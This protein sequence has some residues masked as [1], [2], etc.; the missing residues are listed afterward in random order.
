M[1]SPGEQ[2]HAP[3]TDRPLTYSNPAELRSDRVLGLRQVSPADNGSGKTTVEYVCLPSSIHSSDP[4]SI[5]AIH[6]LDTESPHTWEF[7]K[8]DGSTVINWLADGDMLPAAVPEARIF[9]Y[10]WDAGCFQDAPVETL[11]GHATTLL[12]ALVAEYGGAKM[13]PILFVASC[14]GGLVV[15]EVC[16]PHGK[17]RMATDI[18]RPSIVPRSSTATETFCV[19][20]LA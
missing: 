1:V 17:L 2:Q 11:F 10:D 6:G 4:G 16:Q 3:R 7:D 8:K 13:R 19:L 12:N 20:P 9:T 14:F 5:I 15:A 18:P